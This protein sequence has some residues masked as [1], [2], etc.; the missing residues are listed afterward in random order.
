MASV[1]STLP[2]RAGG[3][4]R[5]MGAFALVGVINT[6]LD[7]AILNGLIVLTHHNNGAWLFGFDLFAFSAGMLSS[8][9]L[10]ARITF[11]Q[12][13]LAHGGRILR[14]LAVS[15]VGLLIN[16]AVVLGLR[17]LTGHALPPTLAI[18]GAKLVATAA[19]LCWNYLAQRRWVFGR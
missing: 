2:R 15:V 18:N 3:R 12:N 11:G 14:F 5:E 6:A 16:G 17:Q 4:L 9:L 7:F 19:S 1:T 10:N 8:Y 13:D